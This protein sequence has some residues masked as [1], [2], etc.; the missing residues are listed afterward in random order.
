[1][2]LRAV[3]AAGHLAA[4]QPQPAV[5]EATVDG[6]FALSTTKMEEVQFAVGEALCFAFG[7]RLSV[8]VGSIRCLFST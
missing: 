1:M 4:S 5:L 7:G 8:P 6:L 3:A 2:V